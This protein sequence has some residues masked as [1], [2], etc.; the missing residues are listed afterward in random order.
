[1]KRLAYSLF[2]HLGKPYSKNENHLFIFADPRSGSTWL[3]EVL[4]SLEDYMLVDEPL[5]L[6]NNPRLVSINWGWRQLIP[7]NEP[8]KE[9][10]EY[11]EWIF[12]YKNTGYG[13][14]HLNS[15][16]KYLKSSSGVFKM[17]R[18]KGVLP[19]LV[20][21]FEFKYKPILLIRNPYAVISSMITHPSWN[22]TMTPF[23]IPDIPFNEP[24]FEH[25]DFL[26]SLHTKEEQLMALWCIVNKACL[27]DDLH[28]K[29]WQLI[30]YEDIVST[31]EDTLDKIFSN[32]NLEM[33]NDLHTLMNK[34]SSTY[35]RANNI[36]KEDLLNGW[37]NIL[38]EDQLIKLSQ[39][40][41]YFELEYDLI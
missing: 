1:M 11:F 30:K 24:Y 32:W 35:I 17:I 12:K 25:A 38:K 8:W 9:A 26:R 39:V 7:P 5:H 10:K 31:P 4:S 34:P 20:Q 15:L 41:E 22:Y 2:Q 33:P 3:A 16:S 40:L 19:W 28:E 29:G 6:N 37:K 36:E 27:E 18:G 14:V 13:K 21:Q 23:I